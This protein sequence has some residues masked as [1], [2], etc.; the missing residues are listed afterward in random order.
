MWTAARWFT[1]RSAAGRGSGVASPP[2]PP[3]TGGHPVTQ[4][5]VNGGDGT[6]DSNDIA[7]QPGPSPQLPLTK[8]ATRMAFAM[9]VRAGLTP[10]LVGCRE[11]SAT[12]MFDDPQSRPW[13]S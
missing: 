3:A 10:P 6:D 8:P 4:S 13:T 5:R 9:T 11:A 7:P 2:Y 12:Q 1:G